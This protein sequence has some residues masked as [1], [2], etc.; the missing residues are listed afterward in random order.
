MKPNNAQE[1]EV[2]RALPSFSVAWNGGGEAKGD[3][4]GGRRKEVEGRMY[5]I[6]LL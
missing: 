2:S 5:L 6:Q 4:G 3:E 1:T